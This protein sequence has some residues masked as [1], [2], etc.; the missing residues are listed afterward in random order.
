MNF[1]WIVI[2]GS[3]SA[4]SQ[5]LKTEVL[6][7]TDLHIL[8]LL[9]TSITESAKAFTALDRQAKLQKGTGFAKKSS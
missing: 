6:T 7:G 1:I 8:V 3:K 5:F 9:Y 2:P 4:H